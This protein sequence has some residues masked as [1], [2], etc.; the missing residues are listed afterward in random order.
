MAYADVVNP[1][2]EPNSKIIYEAAWDNYG[3]A[4]W[5]GGTPCG[6]ADFP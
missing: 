5:D 1:A 3:F 4:H 6:S 2:T